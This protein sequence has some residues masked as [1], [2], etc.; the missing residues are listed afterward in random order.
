MEVNSYTLSIKTT[1]GVKLYTATATSLEQAVNQLA[2]AL[3]CPVNIIGLDSWYP[4]SSNW[5]FK[6]LR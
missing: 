6:T 1:S 4:L 3:K 5:E 2:N